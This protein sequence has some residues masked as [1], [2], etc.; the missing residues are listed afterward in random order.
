MLSCKHQGLA[1]VFCAMAL[2]GC[3]NSST[4]ANLGDGLEPQGESG[5]PSGDGE[6]PQA[7]DFVVPSSD[8]PGADPAP[9]ENVGP[10]GDS[11]L[12]VNDQLYP[13]D[14]ALGDIWGVTDEH[15]NVNFTVSNGRY[16][17][18]LMEVDGYEYDVLTP[19]ATSAILHAEMYSPGDQFS[20][21]TYSFSPFGNE[22]GVLAG[23]AFFDNAYVGVD[24]DLSGDVEDDEKQAVVGGTIDFT[25]TLPDIEL[26]F[27]VTLEDGQ[28]VEG[29]YTGLFDFTSR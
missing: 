2:Q 17:P 20:L 21:V 10:Q 22:G 19:V 5:L 18:D 12:L 15:F 13:L 14:S 28:L 1:I 9:V 25:G 26:H 29:H 8:L 7:G 24:E 23:N 4:T 3:Q 11:S 27:S 16:R 6:G